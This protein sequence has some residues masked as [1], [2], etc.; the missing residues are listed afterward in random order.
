MSA[1]QNS[2]NYFRMQDNHNSHAQNNI[3]E[4]PSL[5][6]H[7][8]SNQFQIAELKDL[9]INDYD[10]GPKIG[11]FE[12]KSFHQ[13]LKESRDLFKKKH[14]ILAKLSSN[15]VFEE[16][17][18]DDVDLIEI[19]QDT[20]NQPDILYKESWRAILQSCQDTWTIQ[21]LIHK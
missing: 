6:Q 20:L 2:M 17:K 4:E 1:I 16:L 12:S 18:E 3:Y 15:G 21:Q 8:K 13:L 7:Q 14:H 10:V 11:T 9:E 5:I 19:M